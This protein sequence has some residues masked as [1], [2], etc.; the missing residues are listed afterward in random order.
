MGQHKHVQKRLARNPALRWF[1]W[2]YGLS[3]VVLVPWVLHL[4]SVLPKRVVSPHWHMAWVGLDV[5]LIVMMGLNAL[6]LLK[7]SAWV[8]MS[9]SIVGG[10]LVIDAWFDLLTSSQGREFDQAVVSAACIE[11]PL[12]LV[13]F[14]LA[15][16]CI[17]EL[18]ALPRVRAH[19]RR[20]LTP[21]HRR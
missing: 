18:N 1:S 9:A 17:R 5:M 11:I 19:I 8:I 2:L 3:A 21:R 16:R 10:M 7:R 4:G 15:G 20:R 14:W 12:A 6:A 13:S